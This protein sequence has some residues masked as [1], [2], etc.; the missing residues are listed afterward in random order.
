LVRFGDDEDVGSGSGLGNFEV[1]E[2]IGLEAV[3]L[4]DLVGATDER[5]EH[6]IWEP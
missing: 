3:L 4:E 6:A 5:S 2:E 1:S